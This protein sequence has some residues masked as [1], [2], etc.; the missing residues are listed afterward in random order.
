MSKIRQQRTADQIQLILSDLFHRHLSD[1]RLQDLTITNVMIDRELEHADIYV[2]ALGDE[3]RQK[4]VMTALQRASGFLRHE[5]SNRIRLRVV[6][7]LH[8]HWDYSLAHT[9]EVNEILDSLYIPPEDTDKE[10]KD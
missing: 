10:A 3:S 8:F 2:N 4:E 1:P 7:Q 6:P 9:E 5:L